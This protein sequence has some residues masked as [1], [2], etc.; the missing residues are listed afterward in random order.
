MVTDRSIASRREA[1]KS[2][3]ALPGVAPTLGNMKR[4]PL[5]LFTLA[6]CTAC[7]STGS[8]DFTLRWT[9]LETGSDASLRGI[10][11]AADGT[12]W[13]SGSGG[14]VLRSTDRGATWESV[15][16]GQGGDGG[17]YRDVEAID[18]QRSMAIRITEPARI[19]ATDDGG[20]SWRVR[21]ESSNPASFFD[22][23]ALLPGGGALVFGDPQGG[24][25]ELLRSDDGTAFEAVEAGDLPAPLVNGESTEGAFAASG[26]CIVTAGDLAWVGTGVGAAR[27]LR[28]E[29]GGRTWS[30]HETPMRTATG[31]SGIYS[32]AFRDGLHGML[33]GGDYT[34]PEL[35]GDNAAWSGDGG[36]TWN[37]AEVFPGGYRSGVAPVSGEP[38][39]WL[40]V[41]RAGCSWSRDGGRTWEDA[42][43]GTGYYAVAFGPG[44]IGY[45]VGA[46]GR[47]AR[48]E[49][50]HTR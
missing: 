24:V 26:T 5:L 15:G 46:D 12:V 11:V 20:R 19:L 4:L 40:A 43:D 7:A 48:I 37:P 27:V 50:V 3:G 1:G 33:V 23:I 2:A 9:P 45:A 18:A 10:S 13:A 30:A 6:V 31:T 38:E 34:E 17:D 22:S 44:G 28:S 42:G 47:A 32:V 14:T 41:G 16:P 49:V 29:D 21:H 36:R 39:A 8:R 25:F 35:G